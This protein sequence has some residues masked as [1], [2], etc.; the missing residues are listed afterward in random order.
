MR[1]RRR[2]QFLAKQLA[3]GGRGRARRRGSSLRRRA[4][5]C[6]NRKRAWKRQHD[7]FCILKL[8]LQCL[9][10]LIP[11]LELLFQSLKLLIPGLELLIADVCAWY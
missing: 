4:V 10:L 8:L 5:K 1:R 2:V 6:S 3:L 11:S 7:A 9:K